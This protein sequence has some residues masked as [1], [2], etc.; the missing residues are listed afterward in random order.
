VGR[1]PFFP[2]PEKK[3]DV[4]RQP[5]KRPPA[6]S[7]DGDDAPRGITVQ[8]PGPVDA[9]PGAAHG[10]E[11]VTRSQD[12][13][14]VVAEAPSSRGDFF[15]DRI[16]PL[17]AFEVGVVWMGGAGS[18]I[19]RVAFTVL[20][21]ALLAVAYGSHWRRLPG[22]RLWMIGTLAYL[23]VGALYLLARSF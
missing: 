7:A 23:V 4:Y 17:T 16:A 12:A 15:A 1:D 20:A 22:A 2:P 21:V 11:L 9:E 10:G 13:P 18:W 6:S 3:G 5:A 8:R 14:R 19:D